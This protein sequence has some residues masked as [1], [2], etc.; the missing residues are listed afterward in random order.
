[1]WYSHLLQEGPPPPTLHTPLAQAASEA[2]LACDSISIVRLMREVHVAPS[3]SSVPLASGALTSKS[4]HEELDDL[5]ESGRRALQL[6]FQA[7]QTSVS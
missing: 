2:G 5:D 1:M 3:G 6:L 7:L 4:N